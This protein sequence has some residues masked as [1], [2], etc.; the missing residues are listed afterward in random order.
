[1]RLPTSYFYECLVNIISTLIM[2]YIELSNFKINLCH[3]H[4]FHFLSV[5]PSSMTKVIQSLLK[6]Y[7]GKVLVATIFPKGSESSK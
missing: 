3:F 4:V 7:L 6:S 5:S 1:M 2:S